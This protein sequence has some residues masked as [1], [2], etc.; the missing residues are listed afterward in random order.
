MKMRQLGNSGLT[1]S[2][3]GMG[4]INLSFGTGKPD[5][6]SA[7]QARMIASRFKPDERVGQ[8]IG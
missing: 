5:R 3:L 8:I 1:V 4:A 2:A 7:V 6:A